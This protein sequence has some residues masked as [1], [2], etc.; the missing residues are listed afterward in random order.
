MAGYTMLVIVTVLVLKSP[1]PWIE[2]CQARLAADPNP[3]SCWSGVP[4]WS[5]GAALPVPSSD[6]NS[7][8]MFKTVHSVSS[9]DTSHCA[10]LP[11]MNMGRKP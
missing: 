2:G 1:A 6:T 7:F 11:S 9:P 8:S 3:I 5:N 10:K 4:F